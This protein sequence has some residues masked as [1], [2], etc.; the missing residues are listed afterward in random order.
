MFDIGSPEVLLIAVVALLVLG[1][2]RMPEAIR[3]LTTWWG[4]LKRQTTRLLE[5][6]S[7]EIGFDR[8][9]QQLHEEAM[10]E[11]I[12]AVKLELNQLSI[13]A[14]PGL[15]EVTDSGHNPA[16]PAHWPGMPPPG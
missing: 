6:I 14:G 5:Q 10:I 4:R 9:R 13:D 8:I 1:P 7:N 15:S 16:D 11:E 12:K 3:G 2:E